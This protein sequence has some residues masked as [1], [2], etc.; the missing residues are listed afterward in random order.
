VDVGRGR[1]VAA[2]EAL[3]ACARTALADATVGGIRHESARYNVAYVVTFAG[4]S[5]GANPP[6]EA[7]PTASGT[8]SGARSGSEGTAQ[9][10]W[11]V[12]LIRDAPKTGKVIARLQRGAVLKVGPVNDGWYPVKYGD[13]F[14]SE[15]W[16]YR[17][18][19]G[20]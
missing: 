13:D 18:A 8:A 10:E 12:A 5:D 16:V 4:S 3:L 6:A 1:N 19:I 2:A 14:T 11:E 9:V 7:S 15:G 17:G 20:R